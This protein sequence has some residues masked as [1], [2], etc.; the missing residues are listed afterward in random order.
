MSDSFQ[1][2]QALD[3][4]RGE[5]VERLRQAAEGSSAFASLV[6]AELTDFLELFPEQHWRTI[7]GGML[8]VRAGKSSTVFSLENMLHITRSLKKMKKYKGFEKLVEGFRNPTQVSATWFEVKV[9]EWCA[10]RA[11]SISLEFSPEV[12]VKNRTKNPEFLWETSLGRLYVECKRAAVFENSFIKRFQRLHDVLSEE[13]SRL[14]PWEPA[15]RLDLSIE[16]VA[17]N[18]IESR[19]RQVIQTAALASRAREPRSH[20]Q[21]GEVLADLRPRQ[22]P[23]PLALG[24]VR[25][26]QLLVGTEPT[27]V[28]VENSLFTFSMSLSAYRDRAV[29]KLLREARTQLPAGASS[30]AF[31]E[32][33]GANESQ[34]KKVQSLLGQS[35]YANTPWVSIWS[36]ELQS[37]VWRDDQPFDH[38]LLAS[39]E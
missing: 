24:S 35:T 29:A 20:F 22:E 5:D 18:G 34:T 3:L 23:P 14:Q 16:G 1:V 4:S 12:L 39:A 37:A 26:G 15:L 6:K 36:S 25:S 19:L 27:K 31:I 17:L 10:G 28:E 7:R 2:P 13:Y 11:V 38:R 8:V 9:A 30:A 21:I 32:L 33:G